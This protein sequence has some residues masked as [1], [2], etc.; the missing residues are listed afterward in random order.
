[1]KIANYFI[2]IVS[3]SLLT[4]CK[5]EIIAPET[6]FGEMDP[7][8][9]V[10][11]GSNGTA[12][13]SDDALHY[14]GQKYS[15]AAILSNQ[16][17]RVGESPFNQPILLESS[18][19][20]NLLDQSR[21]TLGY[22]TDCKGVTSLSPVRFAASGDL[23]VLGTSAYS[24]VPFNNMGVPDLSIQNVRTTGYGNP[25]NGL[26]NFNRYFARMASNQ[27]GSSVLSDAT[28]QNATFFTIALG[29]DDIM[30]Y[31]QSGGT[32]SLPTPLNG[33]AGVGFDG[34]LSEIIDAMK[35][36]GAKGAISNVPDVTD[37]PYFTTIPYN[38]LTLDADKA[39]TMNNVFNPLGFSFQV[40]ANPFV[41]EDVSQPFGVRKMEPGELILLSIPLDS[42]KCYGMGSIVPIPNKYILTLNEIAVIQSRVVGY[43]SVIENLADSE[44]LALVDAHALMTTLKAGIVYNGVS[45]STSFITGGAFSL[46]G[47]NLN[48]RGHALLA[49]AYIKSINLK[50]NAKIPLANVSG[51]TGIL[52]P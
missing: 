18:M 3:A 24:G 9:Y 8:V 23:S 21:L 16:F 19:G 4:A 22:K 37:Y 52:F 50:F 28:M 39:E 12:G 17:N 15:Y 36:N 20:I 41:M 5:P 44:G 30:A 35:A 27:A 42:V 34:S 14:R 26:G 45:M 1:M 51:Y 43:N 31:A 38:G 10:A 2:F 46:D 25:A 48:P 33:A 7:S 29:E 32:S 11:I 49:N 6:N 47:R 40:G 13:Y